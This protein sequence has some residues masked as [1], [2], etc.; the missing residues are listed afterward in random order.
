[1]RALGRCVSDGLERTSTLSLSKDFIRL[2]KVLLI[3]A[4]FRAQ[5]ATMR[6]PGIPLPALAL[7]A[8]T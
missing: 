7:L 6:S 5:G 4:R 2:D 3:P 8:M 1:M